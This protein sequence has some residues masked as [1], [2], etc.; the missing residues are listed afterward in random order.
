MGRLSAFCISGQTW[1]SYAGP[2]SPRGH[3]LTGILNSWG[4]PPEC[5]PLERG[6]GKAAGWIDGICTNPLLRRS[7]LCAATHPP[8]GKATH[9]ILSRLRLLTNAVRCAPLTR[10]PLPCEQ[11]RVNFC[12]EAAGPQLSTLSFSIQKSREKVF[13][14]F[15]GFSYMLS[16]GYG[17]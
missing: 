8:E 11:G 9:C 6:R 13:L 17:R 7:C 3:V 2:P 15:H 10:S 12:G 16:T 5:R 14:L 1:R 4:D